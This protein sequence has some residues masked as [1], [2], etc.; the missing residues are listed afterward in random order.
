MKLLLILAGVILAYLL[1]SI[2]TAV[3]YGKR[4][5]GVDVRKHG[6]GNAGATNTF[7]VLGKRAGS[8]VLLFD[9]LKGAVAAILPIILFRMGFIPL[10]QLTGYKLVFGIAAVVGHIFPV[11]LNF[12]GGKGVA[13]LLGMMLA[14]Q[15]MVA[16]ICI[17][18]F[19]IALLISKYVSLSS[20]I[21][22]LAFPILLLLPPFKPGGPVLIIFG[23]LMFVMLVYTHRK[24]V[25]RIL[26]GDESRTYLLGKK[27]D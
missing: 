22:A 26:S 3:W 25:K 15:P 23:F 12:K 21:A 17:S 6:S 14:I 5:F 19:L 10:D 8:V 13:T 24:N 9:V 1:G 16:L 4:Y 2:P 20:M 27:G 7:R 18:V 11:Y